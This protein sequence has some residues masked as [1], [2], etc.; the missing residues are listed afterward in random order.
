MDFS[1]TLHCWPGLLSRYN[2]L[3]RAGRTED[4]ILEGARFSI[5]VSTIPETQL[6]SYTRG[7][8]SFPGVKLPECSIDYLPPPS[9]EAKERIQLYVNSLSLSL[10]LDLLGLF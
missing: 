3:L 2:D 1:L 7:S 6:A 4:R 5:L 9:P 10:S 8:G